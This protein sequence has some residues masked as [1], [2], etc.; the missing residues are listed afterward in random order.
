MLFPH[1]KENVN[2]L[3]SNYVPY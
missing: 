1:W 2:G 3:T